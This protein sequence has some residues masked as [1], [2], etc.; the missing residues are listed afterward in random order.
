MVCTP[1]QGAA[2]A[3]YPPSPDRW[4]SL[5][6]WR[7]RSL[8]SRSSGERGSQASPPLAPAYSQPLSGVMGGWAL[9][10]GGST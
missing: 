9:Q 3:E 4:L 5:V 6:P 7:P 10:P 1:I 8:D 2:K